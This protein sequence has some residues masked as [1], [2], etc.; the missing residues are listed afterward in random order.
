MHDGEALGPGAE[1][2]DGRC[3]HGVVGTGEDAGARER[4]QSRE[5]GGGL[6]DVELAE[7]GGEADDEGV[8]VG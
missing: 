1:G 5:I 7:K 4:A 2:D 6:M 3:E 8:G